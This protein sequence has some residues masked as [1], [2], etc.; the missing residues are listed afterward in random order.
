M[1]TGGW[2]SPGAGKHFPPLNLS[3]GVMPTRISFHL[4]ICF[5]V[6]PI[7]DLWD[8]GAG[9]RAEGVGSSWGCC[10]VAAGEKGQL[11]VPNLP[12]LGAVPNHL[13]QMRWP[14][15]RTGSRG[16]LQPPGW[17]VQGVMEQES[18]SH[19]PLIAWGGQG[20]GCSPGGQLGV[21]EGLPA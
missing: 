8:V 5:G 18:G 1:H 13:G 21:G 6:K 9:L 14:V 2:L 11:R 16:G 19:L 20:C 17:V 12:L 15:D 4:E 10:S 7:G 3:S